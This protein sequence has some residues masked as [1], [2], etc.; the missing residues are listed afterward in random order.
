MK[1]K[2]GIVFAASIIALAGIGVSFAGFTDTLTAFGTVTTATV[3]HEIIGYSGTWVYKDLTT[4]ALVVSDVLITPPDQNLLLVASATAGPGTPGT[5]YDVNLVWDNIFPC[6]DFCCDFSFRYTGSIPAKI[7][8]MAVVYEQGSEWV[9]QYLTFSFTD[10]NGL[11]V[12]LGYQLH[13][14]DIV[15]C[16]FCIHLEQDNEL[17][18]LTA[19]GSATLELIQWNEGPI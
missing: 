12:G 13:Y 9:D 1:N 10:V 2:I 14:G 7:N 15:Y 16:E 5:D 3:S 11:P 17:Q 8:A 6:T 18:G 4:D 19:H